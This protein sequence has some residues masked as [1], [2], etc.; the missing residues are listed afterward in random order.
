MPIT[1]NQ[2]LHRFELEEDGQIAFANYRRDGRLVV[3]PHVEAA[4][5]LR[6]KGT[7][8]R[9]MEGIVERARAEGFRVKPTC[10]YAHAWFMRNRA[11]ADVL[12]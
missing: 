4:P 2:A 1:D 5:A 9:L 10:S 12:A 7:A 11:A 3:I 6:G 8:S